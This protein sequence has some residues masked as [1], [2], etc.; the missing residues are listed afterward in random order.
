MKKW[1]KIKEKHVFFIGIGGISMSG[2][3]KM[4]IN[5]GGQVSGSDI[6]Y[7]S[8]LGNLKE[9][10]A[11]IYIGHNAKNISLD[12]DLVVFSGAIQENNPEIV[13]ARELSIDIIER[14]EFLGIITQEYSHVIAISGTHGKTTTT[15][16]LGHIFMCAGLNPTIH[17]GGVSNNL[18]TNT[19]LGGKEYIIVEA[20]EYRESFKYL[21]PE[22]LVV[23]NIDADHLDYYK[24]IQDIMGAFARLISRSSSVIMPKG[25]EIPHNEKI[26]VCKDIV[27]TTQG[28]Y[29]SAY[30]YTVEYL[31]K[32]IGEFR[33]NQIGV[34]NIT[35]S[36]F[37]IATAL[38]YGIDV[39]VIRH[40]LSTFT[41]VKR[42]FE[43]I[44]KVDD[45]PIIIDYAHHPTEISNSIDG[46]YSVYN[47][48]LIIFQPHTYSRTLKLFEDFVKVLSIDN[49]G[50][51]AMK[52]HKPNLC[53]FIAPQPRG[54]GGVFVS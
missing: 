40:A 49:I 48:P 32:N 37:A 36:L 28:I 35:N 54:V 24:D 34:F 50:I 44:A 53:A 33:L 39:N 30:K 52:T 10:G 5:S 38:K 46:I 17:L 14:S 1:T 8:E 45:I 25:I 29:D 23:T 31:G 21:S 15:A 47:N 3:A 19:R 9:M 18:D 51:S 4:V 6:S 11:E 26:E 12:I 41:G 16:M 13:K 42:R 27:V 43:T 22:T 20:C 2:L 7:S